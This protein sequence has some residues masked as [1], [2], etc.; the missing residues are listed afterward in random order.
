MD[1]EK[2]PYEH[3]DGFTIQEELYWLEDTVR[4]LPEKSLIVELGAWKGR[5][6]GAMLAGM[7]RRKTLVTVDT[8]LGQPTMR[9]KEQKEAKTG[10]LFLEFMSNMAYLGWAPKWYMRSMAPGFYYL[11]MDSGD[12]ARLFDDLSVDMVFIDP[13]HDQC[14]SDCGCWIPKLKYGGIASGHDYSEGFPGVRQAVDKR[15][16][17]IRR[18]GSIW[19][20]P[21]LYQ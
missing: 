19:I 6:T 17:H 3:I 10:D 13:D 8:W 7:N 11:R 2:K 18:V 15:F 9:D 12:A 16:P 4:K 1:N 20:A 14:E 21:R 5:S